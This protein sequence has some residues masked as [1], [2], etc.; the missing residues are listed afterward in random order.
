MQVKR[1]NRRLELSAWDPPSAYDDT[2]RDFP[3]VDLG[4]GVLG[5]GDLRRRSIHSPGTTQQQAT[6]NAA[7]PRALPA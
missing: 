3:G 6:L 2:A 5:A 4:G 7:Q 1:M